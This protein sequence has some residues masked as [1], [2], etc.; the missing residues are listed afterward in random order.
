M[1]GAG[2][3]GDRLLGRVSGLH[4]ENIFPAEVVD[5]GAPVGAQVGWELFQGRGK[6]GHCV[7]GQ[8]GFIL[9]GHE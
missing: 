2:V 3:E 5:H 4:E 9:V 6:R 8:I 7:W 1:R